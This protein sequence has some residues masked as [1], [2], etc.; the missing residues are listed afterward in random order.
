MH[1]VLLDNGRSTMLAGEL[2]EILGCIRC[3][4]CLNAC[5]VYKSIGG[6]AYGDTYPGP[7]GAIVTP[8]LRGLRGWS[9]LPAA[10]TLCG[11]CRDVCPVR[12]DIPRMLLSLRKSTAE[13]T[14][15]PLALRLSIL[16]FGWIAPRPALYRAAARVAGWFLRR[17]ATDG[18]IKRAP[19]LAAG[20]T[21]LRDLRAPATETFQGLWR[22]RPGARG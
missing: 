19:G 6:H 16:A 9:E 3:G 21:K 22:A 11:A 8:G 13:T 10:S 5:P 1:V 4:A 12:L 2:A 18:W 15:T 20:W 7:I 17:L 14:R